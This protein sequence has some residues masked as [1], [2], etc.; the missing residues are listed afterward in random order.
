MRVV[1]VKIFTCMHSKYDNGY[2]FFHR[3]RAC[4]ISN[5]IHSNHFQGEEHSNEKIVYYSMSE[6]CFFIVWS[7]GVQITD[8]CILALIT[9]NL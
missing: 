4:S 6:N 5:S 1:L 2:H 7:I 8:D 3:L 9:D